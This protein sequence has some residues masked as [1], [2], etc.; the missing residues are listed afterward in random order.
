MR[1]DGATG[2]ISV[3]MSTVPAYR[4]DLP[5]TASVAGRGR[6]NAWSTYS[7]GRYKTDVKE[8]G[9]ALD[10]VSH[11]RGVTY[12]STTEKN[13]VEQVGFIA[14]EVEK[15]L[16]QVV[17]IASTTVEYANISKTDVVPDYRSLDYPRI[18]ALLVEATKELNT[19]LEAENKALRDEVDELK[20]NNA[21]MAEDMAEIKAMLAKDGGR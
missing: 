3:G 8:I 12:R 7:D 1:F 20:K 13:P 15:V 14:Q 17:Y 6:A 9:N 5:N 10:K 11:M 19:K 4:L 21:M 16:P 18:T 2:Y